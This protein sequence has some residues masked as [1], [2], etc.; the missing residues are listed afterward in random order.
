MALKKTKTAGTGNTGEYWKVAQCNMNTLDNSCHITMCLYKDEASKDAGCGVMDSVSFNWSG[1]D[2]PFPVSELD[3]TGKNPIKIA[4]GEIK[5]S[6]K[7]EEGNETNF[8]VD[9]I[10]C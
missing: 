3:K 7:D 1:D 2:Y 8:F 9:A 10:D 4:Y 5:K 6:K